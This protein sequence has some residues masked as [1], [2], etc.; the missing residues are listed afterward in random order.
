[1]RAS[2]A[3][4]L[5]CFTFEN[6]D[7]SWSMCLPLEGNIAPIIFTV[8]HPPTSHPRFRFKEMSKTLERHCVIYQGGWVQFSFIQ[9]KIA[10][11]ES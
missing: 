2:Y 3:N 9:K 10:K 8:L 5:I 1:M 4:L 11:H 7:L 6:V